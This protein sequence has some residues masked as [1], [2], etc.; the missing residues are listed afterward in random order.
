MW[1]FIL[2]VLVLPGPL[3]TIY[4]F[5]S[6]VLRRE[7][8]GWFEPVSFPLGVF[9]MV[10]LYALWH[11]RPWD[12]SIESPGDMSSLHEPFS[13]EHMLTLLVLFAV[14][15]VSYAFLK[16]KKETA[17]PL[18]KVLAMAGAYIGIG[19]NVLILIQLFGVLSHNQLFMNMVP[20][21]VLLMM[22]VPLNY[23]ILTVVELGS[24]V[25]LQNRQLKEERQEWEEE[26]RPERSASDS[27]GPYKSRLLNDCSR[28][29]E[30]S[31]QWAFYAL[32]LTLPLL[33]VITVILLLFGQRP[34]SAI[35]VFTETS[36]WTLSTEI[37]PPEVMVDAHYLCTVALRGHRGLVR[38]VRMGLRRG[39]KI[40]VNRQLCVANAFEQLLEER[41]PRFHRAVRNFYDTCGYPISRHIRTPLAADIVYLLMKPLEWLFTAVLY[42][43]DTKPEDRIARQYLPDIGCPVNGS[44]VK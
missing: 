13:R 36:D 11:P 23:I 33:C 10:V 24:V 28:I 26:E 21:D 43:F 4:N 19:V 16:R 7:R 34:D 8:P 44:V 37:S 5:Y 29:L 38:P 42:L 41:T 20:F 15:V 39:E 6:L 27:G 18:A 25:R 1:L 31:D 3:L 12:E 35:R 2:L 22:L 32:L 14:G 40:V 17:A 30:K 9:F